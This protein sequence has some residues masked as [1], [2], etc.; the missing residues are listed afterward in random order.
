[1]LKSSAGDV[2]SFLGTEHQLATSSIQGDRSPPDAGQDQ[3]VLSIPL[4]IKRQGKE[5]DP[6]RWD[7]SLI[8]KIVEGGDQDLALRKLFEEQWKG[9]LKDVCCADGDEVEFSIDEEYRT[10]RS[11]K[12]YTS[13]SVRKL[14]SRQ[15][16]KS[17]PSGR[18]TPET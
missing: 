12:G 8:K 10:P 17:L 14:L 11:R 3:G 1:M 9:G 6:L 2:E 7:G 15:R 5:A 18:K 13:T 16:Q 4:K